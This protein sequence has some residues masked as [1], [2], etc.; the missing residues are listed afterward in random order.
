MTLWKMISFFWSWPRIQCS[1]QYFQVRKEKREGEE[2][3][4]EEGEKWGRERE[5]ENTALKFPKCF[6]GLD[7]NLKHSCGKT[8]ALLC[9]Q[10]C[11][12]LRNGFCFSIFKLWM[13][14]QL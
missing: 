13:L 10:S 7:L 1:I 8:G 11:Q 2:E 4:E 6:G 5:Q 12:S 3:G 9:E 14:L